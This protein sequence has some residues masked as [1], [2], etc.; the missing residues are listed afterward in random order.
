MQLRLRLPITLPAV[1]QPA[2]ANCTMQFV[3]AH[4]TAQLAL[5]PDCTAADVSSDAG[6]AVQAA[7]L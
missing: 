4:A 3:F 5:Q 2:P 7:T 6:P 1:R